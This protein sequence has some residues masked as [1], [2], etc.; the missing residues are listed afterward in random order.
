[1]AP[2]HGTIAGRTL[3]QIGLAAERPAADRLRLGTTTP[4]SIIHLSACLVR[5]EMLVLP[6]GP[7]VWR[8][9]RVIVALR[10]FDGDEVDLPAVLSEEGREDWLTGLPP[11]ELELPD[12]DRAAIARWAYVPAGWLCPELAHALLPAGSELSPA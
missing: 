5:G 12:S 4:E 8:D 9:R 6:V 1:V 3:A 2:H 11:V 10:D 7:S